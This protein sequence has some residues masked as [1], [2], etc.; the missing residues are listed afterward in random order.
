MRYLTIK[1]LGE[2]AREVREKTGLN[3]TQVANIVGS[4]QPS[5][6]AAECGKSTRY[7]NVA[8]RVIQELGMKD[9]KGP[10]YLVIENDN[11][12]T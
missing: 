1:Q 2:L 5:V 9:V 4:S 6:S 11:N 12:K 10:F 7:A 8:M 3:Q